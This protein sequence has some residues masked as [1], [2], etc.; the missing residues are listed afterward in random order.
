MARIAY[1]NPPVC[2]ACG[3]AKPHARHVDFEAAFDGPTFREEGTVVTVDD[4]MI[5]EECVREGASLLAID[6]QPMRGLELE[7]DQANALADGWREYALSLEE[8]YGRRPEPLRRGRGR[9]PRSAAR[10]ERVAA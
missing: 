9:P 6:P 7:R 2:L 10:P 4:V 5:C 3:G 1:S 8:T